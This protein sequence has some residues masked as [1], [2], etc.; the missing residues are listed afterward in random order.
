[1]TIYCYIF[2]IALNSYRFKK[3]QLSF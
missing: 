3:T 1:M 2:K